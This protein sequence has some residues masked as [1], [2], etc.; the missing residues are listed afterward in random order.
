MIPTLDQISAWAREAGSILRSGLGGDFAIDR[1]GEIDLVTEMDHRSEDYLIGQIRACYPGH[2]IVSE[3]AGIVLP[4]GSSHALPQ[5]SSLPGTTQAC[6]Y[7]DP[8]DG[9]MNYAHGVPCFAV[10]IAYAI[11]E[12]ILL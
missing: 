11:G 5:G 7:I 8:L 10:S 3:E 2:A 9:T 6:W 4:Q 12:R 1:K